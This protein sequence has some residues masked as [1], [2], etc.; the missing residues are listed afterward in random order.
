MSTK[1]FLSGDE[2]ARLQRWRKKVVRL[3]LATMAVALGIWVAAAAFAPPMA[4][5]LMMAV[6]LV[7]LVALALRETRHGTCPRCGQPIRFE[8]RIE[9][10]RSCSGCN[11]SFSPAGN[12]L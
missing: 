11:A 5:E 12:P 6:V 2:V 8:P 7:S 1:S 4:L 10:P 9:L 3:W